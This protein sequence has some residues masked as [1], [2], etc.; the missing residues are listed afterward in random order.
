M[1]D[2]TRNQDAAGAPTQPRGGSARPRD[3]SAR[4]GGVLLLATAAATLLAVFGRVAADADQ[5]TLALSLAA[6]SDGRAIVRTRR[7][8]AAGVPASR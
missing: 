4:I 7:R 2:A 1:A 5:D 3:N 6:I 8:G